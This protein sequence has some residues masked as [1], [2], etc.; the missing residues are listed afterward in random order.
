MEWLLYYVLIPICIVIW[1]YRFVQHEIAMG[2]IRRVNR[3]GPEYG[4]AP[5]LYLRAF[6]MHGN[7]P[8]EIINIF[9]VKYEHL[10][11][12]DFA[13]IRRPIKAIEGPEGLFNSLGLNIQVL[14]SSDDEWKKTVT[15]SLGSCCLI[16]F[17]PL[18]TDGVLWEF[19]QIVKNNFLDKTILL[20]QMGSVWDDVVQKARYKIF[21][22]RISDLNIKF[23]E[24]S[25]GKKLMYFEDNQA[26]VCNTLTQIP[27]FNSSI[28]K[29]E[30]FRPI[31]SPMLV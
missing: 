6:E 13:K 23:P 16:L 10:I 2:L 15:E 21:V 3:K 14:T 22:K 31:A 28:I 9:N 8:K 4:I 20:L 29:K 30:N 18:Y 12:Y 1:L 7:L 11:A 19:K 26:F 24:Y 25:P 17:R 27:I 5:V